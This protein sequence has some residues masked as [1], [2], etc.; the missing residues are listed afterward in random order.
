[1]RATPEAI[2]NEWR[3]A[4]ECAR[5]AADRW[6]ELIGP[7]EILVLSGPEL[8]DKGAEAPDRSSDWRRLDNL[9]D[10]LREAMVEKAEAYADRAEKEDALRAANS[11]SGRAVK[12]LSELLEQLEAWHLEH[13]ND[14]GDAS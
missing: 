5:A 1:M 8:M 2:L 6:K 12:H 7:R 10:D 13:P 4:E 9:L 3:K 14:G 11:R